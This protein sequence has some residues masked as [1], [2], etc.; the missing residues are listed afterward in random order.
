MLLRFAYD[1]TSRPENE[2]EPM[3]NM[4]NQYVNYEMDKL[5]EQIAFRDFLEENRDFSL[6][7]L[8]E[9][10]DEAS[11]A[12][13]H[14]QRRVSLELQTRNFYPECGDNQAAR[15]RPAAALSRAD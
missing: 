7:R 14:D 13:V 8:E 10:E 4:M 3:R 2:S 6:M 5:V 1:N 11:F 15:A 12:P 9:A